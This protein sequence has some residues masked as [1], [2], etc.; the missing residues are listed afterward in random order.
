[1][2]LPARYAKVKVFVTIL[3]IILLG[4]PYFLVRDYADPGDVYDVNRYGFYLS[5]ITEKMNI[6]FI[7]QKPQFD[8]KL[9]NIMPHLSALGASVA[10]TDVDNDG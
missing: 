3:F 10:I 8:P 5:D 7:H 6:D 1:M 4:V 2:S 9:K